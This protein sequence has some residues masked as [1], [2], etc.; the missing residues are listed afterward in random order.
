MPGN[1]RAEI[2]FI[3][4]MMVIILIVCALAV[5]FFVK[6]YKKEMRERDK[7]RAEKQTPA[8]EGAQRS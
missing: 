6:T 1:V 4:G 5:Y 3:A 8:G 2:Y 7:Q